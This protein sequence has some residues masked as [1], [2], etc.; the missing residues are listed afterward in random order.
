MKLAKCAFAKM[1]LSKKMMEA[2]Q[3]VHPEWS[4]S[5][6]DANVPSTIMKI[7]MEYAEDVGEKPMV[8]N[9]REILLE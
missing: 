7:T 9:A 3:Y 2:V 6:K 5:T 8:L 4:F 1:E